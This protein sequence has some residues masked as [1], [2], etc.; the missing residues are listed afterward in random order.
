MRRRKFVQA[1]LGGYSLAL[2]GRRCAAVLL[3]A[4]QMAGPAWAYADATPRLPDRA[5]ENSKL[6]M[7]GPPG[8]ALPGDDE[9]V[10]EP[11]RMLAR[12]SRTNRRQLGAGEDGEPEYMK[13]RH[14]PFRRRY[15]DGTRNSDFWVPAFS[16]LLPGLGQWVN[17]QH[18]YGAIYTTI[19]LGGYSY[20]A[21]LAA[22]RRERIER[23]RQEQYERTGTTP[24]DAESD[25]ETRLDNKDNELRRI[26]LGGLVAQGA[27]GFSAYHAFRTAVRTRRP[28]GQYQFLRYEET[29]GD[30]LLAPFDFSYMKRRTTF[31]PLAIGAALM[32]W[33]FSDNPP[34]GYARDQFGGDDAFFTG[35]YSYNAGTHEEAFFRGFIFPYAYEGLGNLFYA[36]ALQSV[37]FA[38][39]HLSTNSFPLPQLLLGYHLGNVTAQQ[40]FRLGEAIFI[41][42]WWDVLAFATVFSYK[43]L[44][45][46]KTKAARVPVLWLP[47]LAFQF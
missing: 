35:A 4:A 2:L 41:H 26:T 1:K 31:I 44:D 42:V 38:L 17:G 30:L 15:E 11:E 39:A 37:V 25:K 28:G 18:A 14:S 23:E 36:N 5:Q 19:A 3:G 8:E 13:D 22:E 24:T 27:G 20:A 29:P 47:P 12:G 46:D 21:A 32:A 6:P 43:R 10:G 40:N 34:E 16:L 33:S 9:R 7:L 45:N